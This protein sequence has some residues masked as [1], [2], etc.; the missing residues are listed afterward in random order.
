MESNYIEK[1]RE[2][3]FSHQLSGMIIQLM[4]R[5]TKDQPEPFVSEELGEK[6][7]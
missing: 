6:F 4:A 7:A 1:E 2:A 5:V 3:K